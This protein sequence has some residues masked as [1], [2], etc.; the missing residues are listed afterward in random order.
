MKKTLVLGLIVGITLMFSSLTMAASKPTLPA[1]TGFTCPTDEDSVNFDWDDV[2]GALKYSVDVEVLV[3]GEWDVNGS[4]VVKFSFG[5]SD[6]TDGFPISQSD[7]SVGEEVFGYYVWDELNAVWVWEDLSGSEARAKVKAL[8]PPGKKVKTQD[9][10]FS[11]WCYFTV[12][13]EED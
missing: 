4:V 10:P 3:T 9:N 7:L 2:L 13:P 11:G 6:R 12:P 1:P 5:T 8:N